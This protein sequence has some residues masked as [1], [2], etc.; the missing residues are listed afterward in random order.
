MLVR[1]VLVLLVGLGLLGL[2]GAFLLSQQQTPP[3][4]PPVVN[5]PPPAH[6]MVSAR[7]IRAG[8]LIVPEDLEASAVEEDKVQPG[9]LRDTP[10]NR[11]K[12]RGAMMRRSLAAGEPFLPGDFLSPG[13]RGFLAAVLEPGMRAITIGVDAVS[14]TAGLIWPGDRIDLLLTQSIDDQ[15]LPSDHRVAGETLMDDVRVIAVDQ[16]LVQGAQSGANGQVGGGNR[17]VT[18]EVSPVDA[19]RIEVAARLGRLSLAVHPAAQAA[20]VPGEP[21]V[22][23]EP[24]QPVFAGDVSAALRVHGVNKAAGAAVKVFRGSGDPV[25][26]KF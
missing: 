21:A 22:H 19:E 25:E 13:D 15:T 18:L 8:S 9:T 6:I 20:E 12:L 26:Y 23:A 4:A 11:Q 7:A 14:G 17:T 24:P 16:Q 10:D 5:A 1:V 2:V 3:V